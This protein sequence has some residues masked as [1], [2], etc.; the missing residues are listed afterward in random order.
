MKVALE[1]LV[2]KKKKHLDCTGLLDFTSI[3]VKPY[4]TGDTIRH[5]QHPVR[6]STGL[7]AARIYW[8]YQVSM[9]KLREAASCR[10]WGAWIRLAV[11][12]P[13]CCAL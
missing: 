1:T 2:E 6:V 7:D 10:P 8:I 5:G 12:L 9:R 13:P 11:S 4:S 3:D